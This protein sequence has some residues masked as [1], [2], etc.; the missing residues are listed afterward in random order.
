[1]NV[2]KDRLD[3]SIKTQQL[4]NFDSDLF[5]KKMFDYALKGRTISRYYYY[6]V[7]YDEYI[8]DK[9][10][11]VSMDSIIS[12]SKITHTVCDSK[13]IMTERIKRK[14][15]I[16]YM[17]L[18]QYYRATNKDFKH[19]EVEFKKIAKKERY[20]KHSIIKFD[21]SEEELTR[22]VDAVKVTKY[23]RKK[24]LF[25]GLDAMRLEIFF[26]L[27][28]YTGCRASELLLLRMKGDID[29]GVNPISIYISKETAK[30]EARFVYIPSWTASEV[31]T[32]IKLSI[33]NGSKEYD[34]M[35]VFLTTCE[36]TKTIKYIIS[37]FN[38]IDC[39]MKECG[40]NANMGRKLRVKKNKTVKLYT[41]LS[42]HKLR[43]CYA[44]YLKKMGYTL[45]EIQ[46]ELGH[47]S[48]EITATYLQETE[49]K[50]AD[51]FKKILIINQKLI[52]GD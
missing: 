33:E 7:K 20:A 9:K 37:E 34:Y 38:R 5:I 19:I 41:V 14:K 8:T 35:F 51:R 25:E 31:K 26:K 40:K 21:M 10:L 3:V 36:K 1:M 11:P 4:N 48:P 6:L 12:F 50:R 16:I 17:V 24:I 2:E 18:K 39:W 29:F 42:C 23:S 47:G 27:L 15:A 32:Y 52:E 43:H 28:Y 44:L 45:T 46:A 30:T 22:L 13:D 49:T